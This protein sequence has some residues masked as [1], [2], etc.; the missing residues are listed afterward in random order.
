MIFDL[1]HHST[2]LSKNLFEYISIPREKCLL[3]NTTNYIDYLIT[4][5]PE[6]IELDFGFI[7]NIKQSPVFQENQAYILKLSND[8]FSDSERLGVQ[9]SEVFYRT[10]KRTLRLTP[11]LPGRN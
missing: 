11:T 5:R 8:L 2:S 10:F 3:K 6:R 4:P 1:L 7:N 9:E